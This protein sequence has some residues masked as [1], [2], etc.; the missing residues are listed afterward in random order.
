[1]HET[2][3]Q[4]GGRHLRKTVTRVSSTFA[5]SLTTLP[6]RFKPATEPRPAAAALR[7]DTS[8]LPQPIPPPP[9]APRK[10]QPAPGPSGVVPPRLTGFPPPTRRPQ[11]HAR[12]G[13]PKRTVPSRRRP[14]RPKCGSRVQ[15]VEA[16]SM[17][18]WSGPTPG[19]A[20][21]VRPPGVRIPATCSS[22]EPSVF[23]NLAL[24]V[25]GSMRASRRSARSSA[26]SS[27][28]GRSPARLSVHQQYVGVGLAGNLFAEGADQM[29]H[30]PGQLVVAQHEY[31]GVALVDGLEQR[32]HG[33]PVH[34]HPLNIVG[35]ACAG[36]RLA[37]PQRA[38]DR[39]AALH[40]VTL[41]AEGVPGTLELLPIHVLIGAQQ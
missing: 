16:T 4:L 12:I 41:R 40:Q 19:A 29:G 31:V 17:P 36:S 14:V 39:E 22:P 32:L 25:G 34:D 21:P 7:P 28:G 9:L 5:N 20:R 10:Q 37:V 38:L 24:S 2:L 13:I 8:P 23:L 33:I 3:N 1:T 15:T 26:P 11:R 18:W 27:S 30:P 35:A 6:V